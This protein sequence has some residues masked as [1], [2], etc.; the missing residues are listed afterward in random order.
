[1]KQGNDP[2]V[3]TWG[4]NAITNALKTEGFL[5]TSNIKEEK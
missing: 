3:S 1:L 5:N 2:Y 4:L